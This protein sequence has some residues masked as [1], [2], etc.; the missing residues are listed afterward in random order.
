MAEAQIR[1]VLGCLALAGSHRISVRPAVQESFNDELRRRMPRTV[2][3]VGGCKSWYLD[4][5]GVNRA[6]WP[7]STAGFWLRMRR[8]KRAAFEVTR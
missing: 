1:Y 6:L 3:S 7:G 4:E 2:W 8:P 5:K